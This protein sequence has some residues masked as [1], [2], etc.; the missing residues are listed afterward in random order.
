M[1]VYP[2][3]CVHLAKKSSLSNRQQLHFEQSISLLVLNVF[4]SVAHF[5]LLRLSITGDCSIHELDIII[6]MYI[7]GPV[8]NRFMGPHLATPQINS[9]ISTVFAFLVLL[10]HGITQK[11][12][13]DDEGNSKLVLWG[14]DIRIKLLIVDLIIVGIEQGLLNK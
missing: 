8:I 5:A 4:Y 13:N 9:S 3:F 1:K 2:H 6:C 10:N 11:S 14:L 7:R 12:R